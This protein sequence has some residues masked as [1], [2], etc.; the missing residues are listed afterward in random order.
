MATTEEV[1]IKTDKAVKNVDSLTDSIE[2]N[3]GA[4]EEHQDT[5]LDSAKDMEVMG[6]SVNSLTAG[7]KGTIGMLKAS[8]KG[9]KVFKIALA[10]T[11]IG[12][13]VV[14]LGAL[15][16]AFT[17]V[18]S[19]ADGANKIFK[20]LG[21]I[22]T[23]T[24]ERMGKLGQALIA[25]VKLDFKEAFKLGTEAVTGFGAAVVDA[26]KVGGQ[27]ADLQV[28]VRD[29]NIE[30]IKM[31]GQ[32][33]AQIEKLKKF[34][35]DETQSFEAR[36]EA[37]RKQGVLEQK[38]QDA[39]IKQADLVIQ[40]IKARLSLDQDNR[41]IQLELAEAENERFRQLEDGYSRQ[42][43]QLTNIN[44]LVREQA[45][46]IAEAQLLAQEKIVKEAEEHAKKIRRIADLA[47]AEAAALEAK[48]QAQINAE[49]ALNIAAAAADEARKKAQE[50]AAKAADIQRAASANQAGAI[51]TDLSKHELGSSFALLKGHLA[52][53]LGKAFAQ[54]GPIGG[55]IASGVVLALFS[56]LQNKL[57]S[58]IVPEPPKFAGGGMVVGPSHSQGGVKFGLGGR[59]LELE[60]GE[61]VMSKGATSM[62][63]PQLSAM[64]QAGGGVAFQSGGVIPSGINTNIPTQQAPTV[65]PVLY[66]DD[67]DK[68]NDR[69]MVT[70][71]RA[72]L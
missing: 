47:E 41:E 63:R 60:G 1:I 21:A 14:A 53:A 42:T 48:V 58:A 20:Q 55:A 11:G 34:R 46:L 57:L 72:T 68:V 54:L 70:E 37:T 35:D 33:I 23:V 49:I 29:N 71:S 32:L 18:T 7:L 65:I 15:V 51:I 39:R 38:L 22:V 64:N 6:V 4:A 43:E 5:L 44:A 26:V 36:I 13:I 16:A 50:A 52:V 31:E 12:L 3:T 66:K 67:L 45:V 56:T 61:A 59:V 40:E 2:K 8:V 30:F 9:L 24:I 25:L 17:N 27:I 19:V 28:R 69:V 62:F 10:A